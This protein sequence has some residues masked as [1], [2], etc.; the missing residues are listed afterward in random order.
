MSREWVKREGRYK[1][2]V[3]TTHPSTHPAPERTPLLPQNQ[4]P[5]LLADP[6][7]EIWIPPQITNKNWAPAARFVSGYHN[8]L[9]LVPC[10]NPTFHHLKTTSPSHITS[11]PP[12]NNLPRNSPTKPSPMARFSLGYPQTPPPCTCPIPTFHHLKTT[13][14]LSYSPI[15]TSKQPT[16]A[17]CQQKPSPSSSVFIGLPPTPLPFVTP[18]DPRIPPPQN[19]L[20]HLIQPHSHLETCG[21]RP[22]LCMAGYSSSKDLAHGLHLYWPTHL[23]QS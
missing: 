16:P 4:V 20:P 10:P 5:H 21:S 11:F 15:P 7:V 2:Q 18:P 12:W 14:H 8:P 13:S 23:S 22:L 19:H 9:P 6:P 1:Y 17:I 3:S